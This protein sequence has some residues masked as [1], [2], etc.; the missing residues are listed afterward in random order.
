MNRTEKIICLILGGVLAW[1][2]FSE[3]GR[4][5]E[6]AKRQAET[7]QAIAE[8][9]QRTTATDVSRQQPMQTAVDGNRPQAAVREPANPVEPQK[10]GVLHRPPHPAGQAAVVDSPQAVVHSHPSSPP[11]YQ[12]EV[13]LSPA[14]A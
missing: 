6:S 2:I 8:Q 7:A 12:I 5:K 3:A 11:L 13:H 14:Q 9:A 1:Y 10:R 4:A